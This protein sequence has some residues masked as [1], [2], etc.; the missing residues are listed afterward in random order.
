M[1]RSKKRLDVISLVL[2]ISALALGGCSAPP[3]VIGISNPS[4]SA[5]S[6]PNITRH[7]I[8][9]TTT[10]RPSDEPGAF[11][12][13]GRALE[14]GVASVDVTI[15]P[16]HITGQ[17]ERPKQLPPDP[18]KE[19]TVIN[20]VTYQSDAALIAGINRE[21]A[22]RKPGDRRLLL[23]VHGFNNTASDATLRLAQ[24]VEDTG[25][26]G[27]PV[28]LTWA[29]AAKASRYVYDLNSALI[30][31]AAVGEIADILVRT[32]AESN[33]VFAHSMGT[34]LTMEGLLD[35]QQK[36]DLGHRNPINH[37]MLAAPDIDFDLFRTQL[38][39]LSPEIRKK[40]FILVSKDDKALRLSTRIAGG[41]PR[42]GVANT[43]ELESLGLTVIDL[44]EISDSSSGSHSKYAGSPEVV[45]LIGAGL[46]S[47]SRFHTDNRS[48]VQQILAA[49]PI[50]IFGNGTGFSN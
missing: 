17:L 4:I 24:F 36:G 15:P 2:V 14:L 12:G 9:I 46:N 11:L 29:S 23:F 41:V 26:K 5:E 27:V 1:H 44:S 25:F 7:R 13:P 18:R 50:R 49:S 37:I 31:R 47:V 28:L 42:V 34:F 38:K 10:R 21:L 40:M 33:D 6:V 43:A 30:A 3:Q 45:Q 35:Q 19:F 16:T 20:P 8:F 22:K 39:Q 32:N 48:A